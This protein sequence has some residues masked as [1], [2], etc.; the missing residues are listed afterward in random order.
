MG[1]VYIFFLDFEKVG[2]VTTFWSV[3]VSSAIKRGDRSRKLKKSSR[4]NLY[5]DINFFMIKVL[6]DINLENLILKSVRGKIK[7]DPEIL[8]FKKVAYDHEE[9]PEW[10][11]K[12]WSWRSFTNILKSPQDHQ[13]SLDILKTN[14]FNLK[15]SPSWS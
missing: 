1:S 4:K 2:V 10:S 11:S 7:N 15:K 6:T 13:K 3:K 12:F 14:N 8:V 9:C 5:P